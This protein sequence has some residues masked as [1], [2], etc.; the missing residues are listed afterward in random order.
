VSDYTRK[1]D[2]GDPA[3]AWKLHAELE[4]ARE[5]FDRW[6]RSPW[7]ERRVVPIAQLKAW[8]GMMGLPQGPVRPPLLPLTSEEEAQLRR[9]LERLELV[10][11]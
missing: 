11:A 7:L 6:M 4:P 1:A 5:A 10:R 3:G 2:N 8:L 9:D